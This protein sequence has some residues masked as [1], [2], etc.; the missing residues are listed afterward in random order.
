MQILYI[1]AAFRCTRSRTYKRIRRSFQQLVLPLSDLIRMNIEPRGQLRQGLFALDRSQCHF[2]LKC[3]RMI[4]AGSLRHGSPSF[5]AISSPVMN[6]VSTYPLVSKSGSSSDICP[7]V[8]ILPGQNSTYT[9]LRKNQTTSVHFNSSSSTMAP[10]LWTTFF[11][12]SL[13]V[14][15]AE[16]FFGVTKPEWTRRRRVA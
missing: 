15:K 2:G 13:M 11:H 16:S 14:S 3:R 5:Q 1:R 8:P 7:P 12:A 10:K 4:A 6:G 9:P